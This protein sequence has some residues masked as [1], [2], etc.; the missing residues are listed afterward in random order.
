MTEFF[1]P[2][3]KGKLDK[4][5]SFFCDILLR[6]FWSQPSVAFLQ[7]AGETSF[8]F[9]RVI[10]GTQQTLWST[11]EWPRKKPCHTMSSTHMQRHGRSASPP[12]GHVLHS[13]TQQKGNVKDRQK[14]RNVKVY[15]DRNGVKVSSSQQPEEWRAANGSMSLD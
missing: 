7:R 15:R 5:H 12:V 9:L 13:T 11:A 8:S 1:F 4:S 10:Q 2:P 6:L 3:F 14:L